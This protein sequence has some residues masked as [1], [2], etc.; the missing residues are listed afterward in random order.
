MTS[1]RESLDGRKNI[2]VCEKCSGFIVTRDKDEGTTPF[3]M[4]CRATEGC[5]GMMMSSMY[6]VFDGRMKASHEWFK[7]DSAGGLNAATAE[8]VKMGGLLLREIE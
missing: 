1:M 7:P 4:K 2:Y 3:M 8:H 5:R 6:R